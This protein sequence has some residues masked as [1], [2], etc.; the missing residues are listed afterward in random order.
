MGGRVIMQVVV[1]AVLIGEAG[2][3]TFP[4]QRGGR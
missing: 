4:R 2:V 1:M 3:F